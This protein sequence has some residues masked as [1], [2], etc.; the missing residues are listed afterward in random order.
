MQIASVTHFL[1]SS[2]CAT[3]PVELLVRNGNEH[4]GPRVWIVTD[5]AADSVPDGT[6]TLGIFA[7]FTGAVT[8]TATLSNES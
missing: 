5:R 3:K 4:Y 6:D 7:F 8:F 1:L 2:G